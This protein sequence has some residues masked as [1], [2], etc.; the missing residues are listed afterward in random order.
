LAIKESNNK[1]HLNIEQPSESNFITDYI[2]NVNVETQLRRLDSIYVKSNESA[3]L[4]TE[5][6]SKA[7]LD[8]QEPVVFE[9]NTLQIR[10]SNKDKP[11][12]CVIEAY[13]NNNKCQTL[14]DTGADLCYI[15]EHVYYKIFQPEL[16]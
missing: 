9:V 1:E 14:V 10:F 11:S 7:L 4:V 3:A 15:T 12:R 13:I 16:N 2:Q 5:L 6:Y 8:V